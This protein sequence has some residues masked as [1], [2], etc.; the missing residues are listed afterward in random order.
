MNPRLKWV[1]WVLAATVLAAS[2]TA[3]DEGSHSA[4][5]ARV[6]GSL[7]GMT[8]SL[9]IY[10][11]GDYAL[12][13]VA[14][15]VIRSDV[16]ADVDSQVLRSAAYPR[17]TVAQ[18]EFQDQFGSGSALTVTHEGLAGSPD[19]VCT[20]RLYRD[21]AWGDIEVKVVNTTER[22][23]SVQAVRTVH[24]TAAPIVDL[25]GPAA[26]DRILSDS[27]SE[28]RPQLAIR[29]LGD[30]VNGVHRAVGS[31]LIYNRRSGQSLFLGALT[32]ER[33]LT[34]F[35]LQERG[36]GGGAS[37]QAYEVVATGTTEIM[38]G[39]SLK[40]SPASEQVNLSVRVDPAGSLSSERLMFAMGP[41]YH[42]QLEQ[43]GRAVGLLHQAR[44]KAP[45]PIGWWSWTAYYF[46]INQGTATTNADWLAQN[47][48]Q[49]GYVYYQIDEGYQFARGEYTTADARLFPRGIG[50]IADLVRHDGLTFGLWTAPFEVSER[51]WVFQ[52]HPEWLLHN[53]AGRAHSYRLRDRQTR[54]AVCA[55]H[56]QP[57][58][59]AVSAA[60]LQHA[61]QLGLALYQNG[62][63]G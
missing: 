3:A 22:A 31:Q 61:V 33:L 49:L 5:S 54:C 47:L 29:D 62:L 34:I 12:A 6:L 57:R 17:H 63:H 2:A 37:V 14:G 28:D 45:T 44:V 50:Y 42:A 8:S 7:R 53:A 38:K 24:A 21:Q 52:T 59:A 15:T 43:Y 58:R 41:D 27:Y 10:A 9:T 25:N 16:E 11:D 18:S 1:G 30:A 32:S 55:R 26:A 51:A 13:G 35:H 36:L 39:E 40:E 48:A 20:L 56:H 23:I 60:D 4:P 46:G 19:L